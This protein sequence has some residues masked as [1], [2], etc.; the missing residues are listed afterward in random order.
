MNRTP[1]RPGERD[2][3][4]GGLDVVELQLAEE[5]S[6][7]SVG[8]APTSSMYRVPPRARSS[9]LDHTVMADVGSGGRK[10]AFTRHHLGV[11]PLELMRP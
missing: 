3:A 9:L 1:G 6:W 4:G 7:I 2:V 5:R 10:I 11:C 8:R